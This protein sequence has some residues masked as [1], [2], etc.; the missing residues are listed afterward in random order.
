MTT[1]D[2]RIAQFENMAAADPENEM[3]HFSLGSAYLQ[4]DRAVEA[5]A[6]FE[7]CIALNPGMSKAYQLC[8]EAMI[9]AGWEDRA[10]EVLETGYVEAAGKGDR[11]PQEAIAELLTSIGRTVPELDEATQASADQAAAD[12]SFIC[13]Q[14][15]QA[16]TP[17]EEPPFRGPLG[18]WIAEHISQETWTVWIGQGTKVINELRLDLSRPEDATVYDEHMCEFLGV[19]AELRAVT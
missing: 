12:G 11:M 8:G 3:A 16:G 10:V 17:L 7:A 15:G 18:E 13:S 2:D 19:P 6:S 14:S 4:A 5:A 1:T 9:K